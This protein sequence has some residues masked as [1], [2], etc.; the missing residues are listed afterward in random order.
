MARDNLHLMPFWASLLSRLSKM[1]LWKCERNF[2]F[3]I[4]FPVYVLPPTSCVWF[5][6]CMWLDHTE[7]FQCLFFLEQSL[8]SLYSL[9]WTLWQFVSDLH[10]KTLFSHNLSHL[11][12]GKKKSH[13][14][15]SLHQ[16]HTRVSRDFSTIKID[17]VLST[18]SYFL[19]ILSLIQLS[20]QLSTNVSVHWDAPAL[21]LTFWPTGIHGL[22]F[23]A[24]TGPSPYLTFSHHT[25]LIAEHLPED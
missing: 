12:S 6:L 20:V 18:I 16:C 7:V 17:K 11:A 1:Q 25:M 9:N 2:F 10:M 3:L 22:G 4:S 8:L 15:N 23:T 14:D 19:L 5:P 21:P 13:T 24:I